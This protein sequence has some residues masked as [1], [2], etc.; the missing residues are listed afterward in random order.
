MFVYELQGY[1]RWFR[2]FAG[3]SQPVV[4]VACFLVAVLL[5]IVVLYLYTV[6]RCMLFYVCNADGWVM[7]TD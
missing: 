7:A 6:H 3:I 1:L 2:S 5:Y 4:L